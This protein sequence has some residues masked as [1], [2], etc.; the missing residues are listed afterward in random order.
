MN[1]M[2]IRDMD[3]NLLRAF[4]ALMH[5]RNVTR[6]GER[7]GLSQP[8]MSHALT[9]LRRLCDDPL[10]VRVRSGMEPT[11]FAQQL[12]RVVSEGLQV[13]QEGLDGATSFNPLVSDRT[14]RIVMS[15]MG[16]LVF[17]PP[18]MTALKRRA[19]NMNV[20]VLQLAR[21]LYQEVFES[22]A[23]DLA[24]GVVPELQA[25]FYQQRLFSDSYVCL[26]REDH[27]RIGATLSL[28]QF[29]EESHVMIEPAG[30]RYSSVFLQTVEST[31]IERTLAQRGLRRR[32][33]LRLPHFTVVPRIV[34]TTDFIATLPRTVLEVMGV[35][36]NLRILAPPFTAPDFVVRQF[37]H[38]R[39][40]HDRANRWLRG[41]VADLFLDKATTGQA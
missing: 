13:L 17:L 29:C 8:A 22:G 28:E 20:R 9:R 18:L 2:N 33:A 39:Y 40:H 34:Q 41:L 3:L 10:F 27:P 24:L 14:F 30:S 35:P 15:D 4:D 25:G 16:E 1:E 36:H 26:V 31:L 37:W 38:Q 7:I 19:P 11:P 32:I 12:G 21:E 5:E 6:A 23:A